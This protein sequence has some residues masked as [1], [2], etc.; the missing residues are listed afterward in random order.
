MDE[1]TVSTGTCLWCSA[2][3]IGSHHGCYHHD[4]DFAELRSER[5]SK[6][7]KAKGNAEIKQLKTQVR[8]LIEEIKAGGVDRNVG[9]AM[10][11]GYRVLH[12]LIELERRIKE[13]DDL[14]AEIQSIK[15]QVEHDY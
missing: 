1:Y 14:A 8:G 7:A 10:L 13:T 5:A 2:A 15:D 6:A 11:Q 12:A 4:P 3:A 9:T